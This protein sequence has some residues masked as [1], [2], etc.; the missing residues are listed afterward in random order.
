MIQIEYFDEPVVREFQRLCSIAAKLGVPV[1]TVRRWPD[2]GL[3]GAL[4]HRADGV[5]I[6]RIDRMNRALLRYLHVEPPVILMRWG[7]PDVLQHELGHAVSLFSDFIDRRM[8]LTMT[9]LLDRVA[10]R[11]G[12]DG[13]CRSSRC[14]LRAEVVARRLGGETLPD[15]LMRFSERAWQDLKW[16]IA[17]GAQ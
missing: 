1:I 7:A 5:F 3:G 10:A 12:I 9:P 2:R 11:H 15:T 6:S 8:E 13:Y 14:E 16:R 17:G 4:L